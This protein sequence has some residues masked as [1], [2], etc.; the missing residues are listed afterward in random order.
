MAHRSLLRLRNDGSVLYSRRL[1]L[2][3]TCAMDLTLFPFDSQLCKLGIESCRL[4]DNNS[5][6]SLDGYTA[7][8]VMYAWSTG[9]I[10]ALKL[11]TIRLPDFLI[12]EAFVTSRVEN[13]ATGNSFI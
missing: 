7:D 8:Q 11:H 2:V 10:T 9:Q 12:K 3:A 1:S 6:R 5:K 13:Y 4:Y